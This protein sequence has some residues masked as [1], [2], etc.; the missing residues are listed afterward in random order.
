MAI[1]LAY[2]SNSTYRAVTLHFIV[3]LML[4]EVGI[5]PSIT[6]ATHPTSRQTTTTTTPWAVEEGRILLVRGREAG[7][8][9]GQGGKP[10][11]SQVF[12]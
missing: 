8:R 10:P 3:L 11:S 6:L 5:K 9:G 1:D 12:E 2:D 4:L 7:K